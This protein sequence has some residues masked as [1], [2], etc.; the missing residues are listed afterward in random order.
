[1]KRRAPL[2]R[3]RMRRVGKKGRARTRR[4]EALRPL[5]ETRANGRCENPTCRKAARLDLDHIVKR[6]QAGT[7]TT[8]NVIALD[9]RCHQRRDLPDDHPRKLTITLH[10]EGG[11]AFA[12]FHDGSWIQAVPLAIPAPA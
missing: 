2:R 7:D 3:T 5:I 1:M 9:R 10:A 4:L 11:Q 6:S 12:V 8:D